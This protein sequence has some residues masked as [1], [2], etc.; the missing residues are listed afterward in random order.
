[1]LDDLRN[2]ARPTPV[3]RFPLDV[4]GSV[5]DIVE[6]MRGRGRAQGSR[7]RRSSRPS[8]SSSKAIVF[9]LGRVYRNLITNAIQATAPGGRVSV[10]TARAGDSVEVSGRPTRDPAFRAERLAAIFDDFVTTKKPRP[11]SGPRD[12]QA[13]RRAARRHHHGR[14]RSRRGHHVHAAV[15]RRRDAVRLSAAAGASRL[16][17]YRKGRSMFRTLREDGRSWQVDDQTRIR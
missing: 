15:S 7:S 16:V 13:H 4:N 17:G 2:V 8:R 6:S 12:L 11:R 9:A 5:A 10:A 1:M 3:E 14:Q